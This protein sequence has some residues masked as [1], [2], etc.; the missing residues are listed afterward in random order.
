MRNVTDPKQGLLSR[1]LWL[2]VV[3][4]SFVMSG[5]C[6]KESIDG[7]ELRAFFKNGFLSLREEFTPC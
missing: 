1:I 4:V 5:I 2:A 6:I 3:I 7:K